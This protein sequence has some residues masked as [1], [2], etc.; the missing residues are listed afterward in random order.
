MRNGRRGTI[1]W[2]AASDE[3]DAAAAS[4]A[5]EAW[6]AAQPPE[7]SQAEW[8]DVLGRL[9][10]G[11]QRL[12]RT[13]LVRTDPVCRDVIGRL[14]AASTLADIDAAMDVIASRIPAAGRAGESRSPLSAAVPASAERR[15][16]R[17]LRSILGL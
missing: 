1:D 13:E 4:A 16:P 12:L 2:T 6:L 5:V 7:R 9:R 3:G 17:S 15:R 10:D 14:D 8:E 11:L